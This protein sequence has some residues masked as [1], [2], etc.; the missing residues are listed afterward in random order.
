MISIA[1]V[2]ALSAGVMVNP[3]QYKLGR[4]QVVV[5]HEG[6]PIPYVLQ[7]RTKSSREEEWIYLK[8]LKYFPRKPMT[9]SSW[10]K[11]VLQIPE[12]L[13]KYTQVCAQHT[14]DSSSVRAAMKVVYSIQSCA[15]LVPKSK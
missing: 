12:N 2:F 14:P 9:S 1:S 15:N 10:R 6:I 8:D 7:V 11:V 13:K 5:R 4:V 3:L